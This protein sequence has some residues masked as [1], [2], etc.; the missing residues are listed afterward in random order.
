MEVIYHGLW[1]FILQQL[2]QGDDEFAEVGGPISVLS[3]KSREVN[4]STLFSRALLGAMLAMS[5]V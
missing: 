2:L 3:V 4:S 1:F 5:L